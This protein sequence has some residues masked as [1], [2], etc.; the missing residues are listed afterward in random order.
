MKKKTAV[1]SILLLT[2]GLAQAE[3][4]IVQAVESALEAVGADVT[5]HDALHAFAQAIPGRV[6]VHEAGKKLANWDA[7]AQEWDAIFC[8]EDTALTESAQAAGLTVGTLERDGRNY[9]VIVL[10]TNQKEILND[11]LTNN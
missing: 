8:E 1:F 2:S 9:A 7:L 11:W 4:A 6:L 3:N 10:D 5:R